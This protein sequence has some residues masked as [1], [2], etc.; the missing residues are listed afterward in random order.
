VDGDV[1]SWLRYYFGRRRRPQS[2]R[3]YKKS[4]ERRERYAARYASDHPAVRKPP[5]E[6]FQAVIKLADGTT[7]ECEHEH[8]TRSAA[9]ECG[10]RMAAA[11]LNG[12]VS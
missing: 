10:R 9:Q 6:T 11:R 12:E 1:V 8:R 7:A 2:Y 4:R 3:Q 5:A